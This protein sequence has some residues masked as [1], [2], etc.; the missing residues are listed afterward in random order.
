MADKAPLKL[1]DLGSGQGAIKEFEA[2]DTLPGSLVPSKANS[3]ANNDITSLSGITTPLSIL[4]GG[5]GNNTGTAAHLAAAA[6]LGTVSQSGG[7]PTGAIVET[8]T[9]ANGS[10]TKWA[11]GT[12]VCT[13]RF[14]FS[15]GTNVAT[16]TFFSTATTAN[17]PFPQ[18][19]VGVPYIDVGAYAVGIAVIPA[20][21]TSTAS[22]TDW[23]SMVCY[24]P[25]NTGGTFYQGIYNYIAIGRWF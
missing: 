4:Q 14:G 3:G 18:A 7:V 5:T 22:P 13:H 23:P 6:I 16:G 1:V 11:D 17:K 24:G 8:G 9:N 15:A 20:A 2:G 19:F 21:A 10:W 12:M 25:F